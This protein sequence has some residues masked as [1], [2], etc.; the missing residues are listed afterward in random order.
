MEGSNRKIIRITGVGFGNKGAEAMLLV[1]VEAIR[2]RLPGVEI[3]AQLRRNNFEQARA[4]GL[5]LMETTP[6]R[7]VF[8]RV[9][10]ALCHRKIRY[11]AGAVIDIGGYQFGDPWGAKSAKNKLELVK[12]R[13]RAGELVFFMPQAW[14]PFSTDG[15]SESIREIINTATLSYAR[16]KTSLQELHKIVGPDNPKVCFAHDIAWNF[17]GADLSVGR[18]LIRDVSVPEK[19][20]VMTVCLTP[21]LQVY[22]RSRG[23]GPD[24][25]YIA[26]LCN[27]ISHLCR[28]HNARLI[29]LEHQFSQGN[30]E[31]R[32]DKTL[33]KYILASLDGVLPVV[34]LNKVLSVAQAKSV[35]GNCDLLLSSRYHALIAAL[36]QQI[37]AVAI[38][39]SHKYDELMA[40]VG[41]GTNIILSS[42]V[43]ED[44]LKRIDTI[45]E[46]MPQARETL[47][48]TVKVMKQ[49]GRAAIDKVLSIIAEKFWE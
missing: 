4:I 33:C 48:S 25:A 15:I 14:G 44:A 19:N 45:V 8:R 37:P 20:N 34:H 31:A 26:L 38:G 7:A 30:P 21:N 5:T 9:M 36:S 11:K 18:Q 35:I 27:I 47:A 12:Q 6:S 43:K 13:I 32:N 17:Q 29:L 22:K 24:N 16:D 23:Q 49:S 1:V 3:L 42:A 40:E 39:W 46:Q 28:R 2:N 10:A 41:L